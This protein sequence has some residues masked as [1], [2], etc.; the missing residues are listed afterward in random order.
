MNQP[1]DNR[2]SAFSFDTAVARSHTPCRC[3]GAP[4]HQILGFYCGCDHEPC[5]RCER[6]QKCCKCAEGFQGVEAWLRV[7]LEAQGID[8]DAEFALLRAGIEDD[9]E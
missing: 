9:V 4:Y 1:D 6:C 2:P 8:A 7:Q 5:G 3:C